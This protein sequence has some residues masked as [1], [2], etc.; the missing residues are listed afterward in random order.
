MT[1]ID[2]NPK[3]SSAIVPLPPRA[4]TRGLQVPVPAP[5]DTLGNLAKPNSGTQDLN[6]KVS[7]ELHTAFKVTSSLRKMPMKDLLD[8]AFR[9][10]LEHN[11]SDMEKKL[12]TANPKDK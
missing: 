6:F 4:R 8:A 11:G 12:L 10:W 7:P 3:D 1:M 2:D 9:F 5:N